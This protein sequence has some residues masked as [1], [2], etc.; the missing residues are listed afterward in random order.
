MNNNL[1]ES[2]IFLFRVPLLVYFIFG[3]YN[4]YFL[5]L[6]GDIKNSSKIAIDNFLGIIVND[7]RRFIYNC[8]EII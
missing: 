6:T 1:I 8:N 5:Y 2:T 3:S 4:L 7:I